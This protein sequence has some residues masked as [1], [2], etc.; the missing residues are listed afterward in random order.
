MRIHFGI[1]LVHLARGQLESAVPPLER[2]MALVDRWDIALDHS[3]C[4][5][6]LGIAYVLSGRQDAGLPLLE[7]SVER[8]FPPRSSSPLSRRLGEGYLLGGRRDDARRWASAALDHARRRGG[9]GDEAWA[10]HLLADVMACA[11]ALD[12]D[13][14]AAL[15]E[16]ARLGA[17]SLGMRPLLARCH[18]GLGTL[19]LRLGDAARAAAELE[20]AVDLMRS[21]N[22]GLWRARAEAALAD[23]SPSVC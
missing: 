10:L 9:R 11:P 17:D 5:S 8:L 7:R 4:A 3:G 22:L 14:A 12:R 20:R 15:Y 23:L 1:G 16:E 6:L 2:A 18:L 13:R 19:N 21:M